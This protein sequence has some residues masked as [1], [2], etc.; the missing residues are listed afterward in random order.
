MQNLEFAG[1][2]PHIECNDE[3]AFLV[4][5]IHLIDITAT[6]FGESFG[7]VIVVN[8]AE[9]AKLCHWYWGEE[10][11]TI[12]DFADWQQE[13]GDWPEHQCYHSFMKNKDIHV[14]TED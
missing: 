11:D 12:Q 13:D 10:F 1:I 5:G 6:Q 7:A 8:R 2:H 4:W 14:F 3:H 9:A